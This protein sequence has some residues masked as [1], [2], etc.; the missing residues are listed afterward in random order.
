MKGVYVKNGKGIKRN[1]P[2]INGVARRLGI[3]VSAAKKLARNT[4]IPGWTL[5]GGAFYQPAYVADLAKHANPHAPKEIHEN[6]A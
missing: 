1:A 6:R 5:N 4:K 2:G 3:S